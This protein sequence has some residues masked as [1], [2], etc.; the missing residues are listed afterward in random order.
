MTHRNPED[1]AL[2]GATEPR[3]LAE[4]CD[5]VTTPDLDV[6]ADGMFGQY[7]GAHLPPQLAG[8]M[9]E[10]A[11]AYAEARQDPEFYAEYRRLLRDAVGRPCYLLRGSWIRQDQGVLT[12]RSW[13]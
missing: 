9:A 1:N 10:V 6:S 2:R 3:T 12:G 11:R 7:G 4:A 5:L 8:P 13:A